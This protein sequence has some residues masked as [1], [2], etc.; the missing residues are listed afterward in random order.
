[1]SE[2]EQIRISLILST[3]ETKHGI[4]MFDSMIAEDRPVLEYWLSIGYRF[5]QIALFLFQKKYEPQEVENQHYPLHPSH[6]L[7]H[8][9]PPPSPSHHLPPP[10]HHPTTMLTPVYSPYP[11]INAYYHPHPP[12][13]TTPH[14]YLPYMQPIPYGNMI[15]VRQMSGNY[16]QQSMSYPLSTTP[17][18]PYLIQANVMASTTY[19]PLPPSHPP[20]HPPVRIS[21]QQSVGSTSSADG[22]VRSTHSHS[23]P[24]PP[25]CIVQSPTT[26]GHPIVV[27]T[28][29]TS[30]ISSA[31][32]FQ[33]ES[34]STSSKT[35]KVPKSS[36]D[37]IH[38]EAIT[39]LTDETA[40]LSINSTNTR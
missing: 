36:V 9:P 13:Q 7:S 38:L 19:P 25:L 6:V 2:S 17:T 18:Q 29:S 31:S 34:P 32:S 37:N 14:G 22:S 15:P 23:F 3:Q 21:S 5:D 27:Q 30:S 4:N 16:Q 35:F 24:S 8:P 20:S 28:R 39:A 40:P 10:S 26:L 11:P 12:P 33:E 1:L